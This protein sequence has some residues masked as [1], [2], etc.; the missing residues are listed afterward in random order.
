MIIVKEDTV[1]TE[2]TIWIFA[3]YISL[4]YN[5]YLDIRYV[6]KIYDVS[7]YIFTYISV[8]ENDHF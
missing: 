8:Y 5:N 4:K 7:I 3:L 2:K 1:Y 6:F